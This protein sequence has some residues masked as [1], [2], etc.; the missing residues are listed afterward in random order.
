[1]SFR[2]LQISRFSLI[3]LF[4]GVAFGAVCGE[5]SAQISVGDSGVGYIDSAVVANQFRLRHDG[6]YGIDK[7]N[8]AEFLWAWRPPAGTGP[9][10]DE[11]SADYQRTSAYVEW[12][13]DPALS[14][15]GDLPVVFSDP[16]VNGNSAGLGDI[17]AGLK[18][19]AIQEDCSALTIQ[20]KMYTPTGVERHALGTGH[21]SVE[22]GILF[23]Q[24]Q[25]WLTIEGELRHWVPIN[26]TSGPEGPVLRYGLGASADLSDAGICNFKP[27]VEV[28][29]WTVLDG[30][31]RFLQEGVPVVEDADGDTIVN[32]KVGG[33][34]QLDEE[35]DVYFGY[36]RAITGHAWY[37]NIYRVEL[38]RSF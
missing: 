7:P 11:S 33:R 31:T 3:A 32:V 21:F 24:R 35:T 14:I 19:A 5:A 8:R 34:L 37:E 13:F 23:Y 25:D 18:Y 9:A 22:P 2:C 27:V 16:E 15:F 1:M 6:A 26:G 38:R 29:G 36:G 30:R 17:E 20:L 4:A 10:R 28:V 12:A